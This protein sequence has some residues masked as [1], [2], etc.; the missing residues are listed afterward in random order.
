M[1]DQRLNCRPLGT[2]F[3]Y[4]SGPACAVVG[5]ETLVKNLFQTPG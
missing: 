2:H 5:N 1:N 3:S 4:L